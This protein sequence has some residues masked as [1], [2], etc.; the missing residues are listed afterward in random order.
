[1][2]WNQDSEK[3]CVYVPVTPETDRAAVDFSIRPRGIRLAIDGVTIVEGTPFRRL[4]PADCLWLMDKENEPPFL[5]L[6]LYKED[7][8]QN[9]P[10]LLREGSV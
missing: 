7:D 2:W 6:E 10:D 5:Q 9:W 8:F 1:Y 4:L 3:I